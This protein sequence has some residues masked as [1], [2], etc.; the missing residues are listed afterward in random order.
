MASTLSKKEMLDIVRHHDEAEFSHYFPQW[1]PLAKIVREKFENFVSKVQRSISDFAMLPAKEFA[2]AVQALSYK[3]LLFTLRKT[4]T[5]LR[6]YLAT[7][8]LKRLLA[9]IEEIAV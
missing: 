4:P 7:F 5:S 1:A 6:E 9:H 2:I 3:S 8:D